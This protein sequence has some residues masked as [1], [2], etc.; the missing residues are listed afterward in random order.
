MGILTEFIIA[1]DNELEL[2]LQSNYPCEKWETLELKSV[3]TIKISTLYSIAKNEEYNMD[4]HHSFE[5]F[6]E[7]EEGPWIS[8]FSD[9]MIS[10]LSKI[11]PE[12]IDIIASKWSLTEELQMDGF[13]INDAKIIIQN[14]INYC[15]KAIDSNSK[16][17][18]WMSL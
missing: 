4:I 6:G 14:L 11:K 8:K 5:D 9:D 3:D 7:N 1:K 13:D 18:L 12:N 15:K 16:I 10:T 17:F 2:I